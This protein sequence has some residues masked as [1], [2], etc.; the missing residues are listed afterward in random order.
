MIAAHTFP[1]ATEAD[2]P[3]HGHDLPKSLVAALCRN[4]A[5]FASKNVPLLESSLKQ[6]QKG[7]S[8]TSR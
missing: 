5:N 8:K 7:R 2:H 1:I 3:F 4:R 6:G